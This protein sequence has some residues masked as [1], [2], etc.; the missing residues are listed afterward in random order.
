M[1]ILIERDKLIEELEIITSFASRTSKKDEYGIISFRLDNSQLI[2]SAFTPDIFYINSIGVEV[3]SDDKKEFFAHAK[4]LLSLVRNLREKNITIEVRETLNISDSEIQYKIP[5]ISS[6]YFIPF[7]EIKPEKSF[8]IELEKLL[9][10]LSK[11][12]FC[13]ADPNE[14]RL[15]LTGIHINSK[16]KDIDFVASN[17]YI[18]GLYKLE[19]DNE[20]P[21]FKITI[22]EK[23]F[24]ILKKI[25]SYRKNSVINFAFNEDYVVIEFQDTNRKVYSRLF[26]EAYPDY[27]KI[28][29]KEF[30]FSF[31]TSIEQLKEKIKSIK[32]ISPFT[33][34]FEFEKDR[35]RIYAKEESEFSSYI[36]GNAGQFTDDNTYKI[37]FSF[38]QFSN[39][40]KGIDDTYLIDIKIKD[41]NSPAVLFVNEDKNFYLIMPVASTQDDW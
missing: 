29:P 17:G 22:Q 1:E 19:L 7:E 37:S 39:L 14:M 13:V 15:Y 8:Q 6:D 40:I 34:H 36:T 30:S 41:K 20:L 33:I 18:L 16:G 10:A 21:A 23:L 5:L 25:Y 31:T 2:L 3:K 4:T 11:V 28:I 9:D 35:C 24:D 12:H 26:S 32:V 27:N 38:E